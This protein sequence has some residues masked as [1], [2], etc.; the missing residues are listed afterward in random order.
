MK[1]FPTRSGRQG[2]TLLELIVVITII[3]LLGT[4]V[5]VKVGGVLGRANETKVT[6]D[7]KNIV[8][9]AEMWKSMEGYYPETLEEM[10]RG[11]NQDGKKVVQLELQ[12]DPWGNEYEYVLEDGEPRAYCYGMDGQEGGDGE[13]QDYTFPEPSDLDY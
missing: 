13:N 1:Y 2:F 7:L 6:T 12:K 4:L 10:R 11:V 8:R 3:G 5:V 9:T